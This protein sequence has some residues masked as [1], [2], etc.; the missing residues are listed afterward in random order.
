[1]ARLKGYSLNTS[2]APVV[3][4]EYDASPFMPVIEG[5]EYTFNKPRMVFFYDANKVLVGTKIDNSTHGKL[6]LVVPVGASY[7]RAAIYY[8]FSP[9]FQVELGATETAFEPFKLEIKK[10]NVKRENLDFNSVSEGHI[11]ENSVT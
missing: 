2:G 10:I 9:T 5:T 3:S 7:A 6:T 11:L 1:D 8:S 4:A